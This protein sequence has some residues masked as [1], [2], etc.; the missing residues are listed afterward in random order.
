MLFD[1]INPQKIRK[2]AIYSLLLLVTLLLQNTLFSRISV[3]GVHALF[4]PLFVLGVAMFEG[5]M[6]GGVF[7]LIAG[8]FLDISMSYTVFFVVL[9]PVVGYLTGVLS[10]CFI[11]R[12][13]FS[14]FFFSAAVL[15]VTALLQMFKP[16]FILGSDFFPLLL[17]A[18]LQTLLSLPFTVVL[19]FPC[20]A[21]AR[22]FQ[23]G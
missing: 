15:T 11:N 1:L 13:F 20:R 22:R 14:F 19:Y 7:G 23:K 9:L 5:Y 12:R 21:I 3:F 4:A 2:A 17:T 16:L 10:D 6:W 8:F 18:F